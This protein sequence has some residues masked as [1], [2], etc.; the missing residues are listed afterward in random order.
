M[1]TV[2]KGAVMEIRK[3]DKCECNI[4]PRHLY[5]AEDPVIPGIPEE[6]GCTLKLPVIYDQE[7]PHPHI[8]L[9]EFDLC[10]TC[11]KGLVQRTPPPDSAKCTG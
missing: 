11:L 5:K 3:C 8:T 6:G 4:D 9:S 7:N 2:Y 1:V 10:W